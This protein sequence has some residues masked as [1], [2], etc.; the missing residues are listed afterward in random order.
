M[1]RPIDYD[2]ARAAAVRR[3][4]LPEPRRFDDSA[5]RHPAGAVRSD[6]VVRARARATVRASCCWR[7]RRSSCGTRKS[8]STSTT[9]GMFTLPEL[10]LVVG[11]RWTTR[12]RRSAASPAR[13]LDDGKFLITLGGEHSI[14]S[15]LVAA[16]AARHPGLTRAADRR[17]RRPARRA[18][19]A[20]AQ[21]R[22]RDAPHARASRR[23]CRSASATS[24]RRRSRRCR[25]SRRRSSTTGTC[26]TTRDWIDRVVDALSDDGL[27]HD[28]SRWT[29]SG[30]RCRP[31][32]RPSPAACRGAS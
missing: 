17:A 14:T 18:T 11:A 2:H 26:A 22:L 29:R 30:A 15:P 16:A 6:D 32:A 21:P 31:S 7:R 9:R 4:R 1:S 13:I 5:A 3:R 10:D 28:R 23:S 12:W 24:R 20:A 27:R 25:R 19:V 8:A